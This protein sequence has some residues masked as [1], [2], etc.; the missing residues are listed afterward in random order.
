MPDAARQP[1]EGPGAR[2]GS[3]RVADRSW[4]RTLTAGEGAVVAVA[5]GVRDQGAIGKSGFHRSSGWEMECDEG[6]RTG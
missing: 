5:R 4:R 1:I 6:G 2:R 3:E